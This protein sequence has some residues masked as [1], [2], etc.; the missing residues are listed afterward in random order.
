MAKSNVPFTAGTAAERR[1]HAG[2]A[3]RFLDRFA[4]RRELHAHVQE[5]R[6]VAADR[7]LKR[8]HVRG[9]KS[10][11]AAV[12]MRRKRYPIVVETPPALQAENLKSARIGENRPVPAHKAM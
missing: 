11:F 6:D 2:Q 7:L 4:R 3:Y 9:R 10:V 5:H 12:K 1:A 8:N